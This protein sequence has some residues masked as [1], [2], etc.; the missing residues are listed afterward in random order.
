[1]Y[2]YVFVW[3]NNLGSNKKVRGHTWP[4]HASMNIGEYF[5]QRVDNYE[6]S[7]RNY[8][9]WFPS[10]GADFGFAALFAKKQRG[11]ALSSIISD[12][13]SEGYFPDHIIRMACS[14][15]AIDGMLTEW[16]LIRLK[17]SGASYKSFR[18]N[19]STIVSRVLHAGGFY[20]Y[21][22][23]L[24]NNLVWTPVDIAKLAYAAGGKLVMWDEFKEHV[25][26]ED[27]QELLAELETQKLWN[28]ELIEGMEDDDNPDH[29]T[30][31]VKREIDSARDSAFCKTG[32]PC[33]FNNGR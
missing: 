13:R 1:M 23:A 32:A 21:K 33:R 15:E 25:L 18:K 10:K 27:Y 31:T 30:W 24:D 7:N 8:V 26:G 29:Y 12:I 17:P 11:T 19:C 3:E 16:N 6:D 4:G 22:W 5:G 2:S 20:A 14:M 28:R 9:S